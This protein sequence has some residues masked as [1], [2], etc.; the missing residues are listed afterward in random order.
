MIGSVV[1]MLYKVIFAHQVSRCFRF[2]FV[3][4]NEWTTLMQYVTADIEIAV[5][6]ILDE[7]GHERFLVK[8]G[9]FVFRNTISVT[10]LSWCKA[11]AQ[12]DIEK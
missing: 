3:W 12:S 8:P 4:P 2:A 7:E 1:N 5:I 11:L 10:V 9:L 6:K